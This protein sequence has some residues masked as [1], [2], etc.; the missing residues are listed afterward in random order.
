MDGYRI[1]TNGWLVQTVEDTKKVYL[2]QGG[3]ATGTV[4]YPIAFVRRPS[5]AYTLK[6]DAGCNLCVPDSGVSK[7]SLSYIAGMPS[8]SGSFDGARFLLVGF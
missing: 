4:R 6:G 8:S 3:I 2:S 1:L 7:E 5:V